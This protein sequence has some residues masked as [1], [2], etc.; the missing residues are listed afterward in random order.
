MES[1]G[2]P[3]RKGTSQRSSSDQHRAWLVCC[4]TV[5]N[6]ICVT[7]CTETF[8]AFMLIYVHIVYAIWKKLFRI[9]FCSFSSDDH[10]VN[11]ITDF[12]SHLSCFPDQLKGNRMD[13]SSLLLH[14]DKK[15][16]PFILVK[17]F[18]LLLKPDSF[19]RAVTNAKPTHTTG[20]AYNNSISLYG[21]GPKRTFLHAYSAEY[22]FVYIK[23]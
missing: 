2:K 12:D 3:R 20:I 21:K 1:G 18:R 5:C 7:I 6:C 17:G 16:F 9:F 4:D 11:L 23:F 13:L 10:T 14:I 15:V 19:L 8:K 22:A